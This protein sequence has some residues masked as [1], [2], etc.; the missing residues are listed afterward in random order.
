MKKR[1]IAVLCLSVL[2][3]SMFAVYA[4]VRKDKTFNDLT[5]NQID[6]IVEAQAESFVNDH[7]YSDVVKHEVISVMKESIL[8]NIEESKVRYEFTV[9]NAYYSHL[10]HAE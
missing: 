8:N 6:A 2:C 7:G 1:I 4:T 5:M 10:V 3:L 9:G